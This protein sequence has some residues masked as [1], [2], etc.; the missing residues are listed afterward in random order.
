VGPYNSLTSPSFVELPYTAEKLSGQ[1]YASNL[2]LATI[3]FLDSRTVLTVLIF[4]YS[5]SLVIWGCIKY[6]ISKIN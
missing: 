6:T 5:M 1:I 2:P 3:F 4:H